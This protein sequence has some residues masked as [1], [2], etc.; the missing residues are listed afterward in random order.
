M[1][2]SRFDKY[3]RERARSE[4]I[5]EAHRFREQPIELAIAHGASPHLVRPAVALALRCFTGAVHLCV[6][7]TGEGTSAAMDE[8]R[9]Y[10]AGDRIRV[11][12]GPTGGLRLGIGKVGDGLFVD[13]A[14]GVAYINKVAPTNATPWPPAAAFAVACGFGKLF[15]RMLGA[16]REVAEEQW[17]FSLLSLSAAAFTG[18]VSIPESLDVP[19][20]L[21]VGSITLIG[22]GAIGSAFAF[23]LRSSGW[24]CRLRIVDPQCYDEPNHETTLL[25]SV[26]D[27]LTRQPKAKTLARLVARDGLTTEPVEERVEQGHWLLDYPCDFLVCAVDC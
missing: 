7:D 3:L 27:A 22:A 2:V 14:A 26:K 6:A 17:E 15:A 24:T 9:T 25:I 16:N 8:A 13:A 1:N 4:S 19:E 18:D 21:D 11:G 5:G 23:I 20:R 10:G 12:P